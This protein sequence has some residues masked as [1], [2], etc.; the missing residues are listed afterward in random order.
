MHETVTSNAEEIYS[1]A[2][3]YP[4]IAGSFAGCG[5]YFIFFGRGKNYF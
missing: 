3:V 5:F 2:F 1:M 4:D